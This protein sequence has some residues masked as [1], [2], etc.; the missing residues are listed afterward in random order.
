MR[1]TVQGVFVGICGAIIFAVF[2]AAALSLTGARWW[3]AMVAAFLICFAAAL[4]IERYWLRHEIVRPQTDVGSGNQ[5][6]ASQE[7]EMR[8]A[9]VQGTGDKRIGSGNVAKGDQRIT[10]D[11]A[12]S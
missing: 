7:I 12:R 6:E 9:T 1:G 2:E 4:A 10:I 3:L 8:D 5:S 11:K